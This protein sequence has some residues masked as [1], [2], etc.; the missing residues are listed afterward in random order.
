MNARGRRVTS[1]RI[2]T[3]AALPGDAAMGVCLIRYAVGREHRDQDAVLA[4][5]SFL[6][7]CAGPRVLRE[8]LEPGQ[9][10]GETPPV[11][12]V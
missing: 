8:V 3:L 6:P 11:R 2:P 7:V 4:T 12:Q 10:I 1:N 9:L 5:G